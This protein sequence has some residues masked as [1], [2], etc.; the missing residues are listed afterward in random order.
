M[1]NK[2]LGRCSDKVIDSLGGG[3]FFLM[4]VFIAVNV[5]SLWFT[6]RRYAQLE[7][8][9]LSGFVWVTYISLGSHYR[10]KQ[11]IAVDFIVERLRPEIKKVIE[12]ISD[13]IVFFIGIIVLFGTWKLLVLSI[14][15]F[16]PMLK[17]RFFWIDLGLF[18]GFISLIGN[19]LTK[20]IPLGKEEDK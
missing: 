6:G 12:I 19:I 18:F 3:M 11:H 13:V 17:L 10:K 1:V 20:Y 14:D 7:E 8:I 4:I 15:K 2:N 9:V 5:L 16:T